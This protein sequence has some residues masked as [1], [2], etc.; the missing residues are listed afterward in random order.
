M[1]KHERT[2][3]AV[4]E[5]D[6]ASMSDEALKG[7]YIATFDAMDDLPMSA[8]EIAESHALL[9]AINAELAAR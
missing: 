8:T 6:L 3:V 1:T 5:P 2:L 7:L 4:T 9:G